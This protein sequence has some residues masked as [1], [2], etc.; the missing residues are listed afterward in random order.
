MSWVALVVPYEASLVDGEHDERGEGRQ[1]VAQ[2]GV[3][4]HNEA[5]GARA[6]VSTHPQLLGVDFVVV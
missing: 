3:V 1:S 2:C 6:A 4:K 5:C